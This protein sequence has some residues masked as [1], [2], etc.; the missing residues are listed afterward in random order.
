M[1]RGRQRP[2][3][4]RRRRAR[5]QTLV[6]FAL[7]LPLFMLLLMAV[8][9]FG[10]LFNSFL[11]INFASREASLVAAEAGNAGQADCLILNAVEQSVQTPSSS[12][13]I[14]QVAIFRATRTG[15]MSG[16]VTTYERTG[17]TS[18]TL[19]GNVTV[20]VPY[21]IN[22]SGDGYPA[23]SRCNRL[24]GCGIVPTGVDQIGVE[25]TYEYAW[26]TP[27]GSV[28]GGSAGTTTLVK[29]N[30]MRMEPVL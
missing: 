22:A 17:S 18:C 16:N 5:G 4:R 3:G 9:E 28:F 27:L 29:G 2:S 30:V 23:A 19:P 26:H 25:V 21:Q 6:E 24:A 8:V 10:F 7:I 1:E 14:T 11:A 12:T 15:A 13:Q 20:D